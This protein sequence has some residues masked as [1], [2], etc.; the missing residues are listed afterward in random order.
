MV[1]IQ[2]A[3]ALGGQMGNFDP[4]AHAANIVLA[5]DTLARSLAAAQAPAAPVD[6]Q[7]FIF[8]V[9]EEATVGATMQA[10]GRVALEVQP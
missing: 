2:A 4:T 9:E 3:I 6:N 8:R 7:V 10:L 1:V 5:R